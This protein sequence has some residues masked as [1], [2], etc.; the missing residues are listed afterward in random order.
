MAIFERMEGLREH[1]A[2]L[3]Q[4]E[5]A[6]ERDAIKMTATEEDEVRPVGD[7]RGQLGV[8]TV[9]K[10]ARDVDQRGR[11]RVTEKL[12]AQQQHQARRGWS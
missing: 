8:D 7:Q 3:H 1:L 10:P 11:H 9:E 4:L 5:R 12:D 6:L 2:H